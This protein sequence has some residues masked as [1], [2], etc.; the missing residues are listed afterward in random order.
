MV[1]IFK[2]F[3]CPEYLEDNPVPYYNLKGLLDYR[4]RKKKSFYLLQSIYRGDAPDRE[5]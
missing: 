3:Y 1:L 4:Y 5:R 2:D